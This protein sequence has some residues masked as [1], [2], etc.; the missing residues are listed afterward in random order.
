[1]GELGVDLACEAPRH[2]H[3]RNRAES[4]LTSFSS[5]SPSPALEENNNDKPG[6]AMDDN[7]SADIIVVSSSTSRWG[8]V[9]GAEDTEGSA[10]QALR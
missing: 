7:D 3:P 8:G 9:A 4:S 1:M 5:S 6:G 10:C 2:D